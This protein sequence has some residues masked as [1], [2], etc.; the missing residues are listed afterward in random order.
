MRQ[1]ENSYSGSTCPYCGAMDQGMGSRCKG[2][3]RL[4]AG[5]VPDWAQ[6]MPRQGIFGRQGLIFMTQNKWLLIVL[7]VITAGAYFLA[8]LPHRPESG[9]AAAKHAE[10]GPFV[11]IG[12][13]PVGD[14]VGELRANEIHT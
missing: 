4:I 10:H 2:C 8:Q 14:G 13:G 12:A 5:D 1:E 11:A 3:G 9:F 6:S 7:I